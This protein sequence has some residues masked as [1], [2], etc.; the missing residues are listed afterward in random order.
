MIPHEA[1]RAMAD[2]T[3]LVQLRDS[4]KAGSSGNS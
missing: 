1:K 3:I 4:P 2:I